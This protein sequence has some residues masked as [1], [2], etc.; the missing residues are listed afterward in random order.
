MFD[1]DRKRKQLKARGWSP[2]RIDAYMRHS[3]NFI[4]NPHKRRKRRKDERTSR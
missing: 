1:P 2:A 3:M 4:V